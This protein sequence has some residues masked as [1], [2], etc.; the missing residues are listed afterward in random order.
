MTKVTIIIHEGHGG[1]GRGR[2][3]GRPHGR[4]RAGCG[5][6]EEQFTG[7]G[8]HDQRADDQP[9]SE[10]KSGHHGHRPTD[11]HPGGERAFGERGRR[12][13]WGGHGR[14]DGERD[15]GGPRHGGP[16]HHRPDHELTEAELAQRQLARQVR[17]EVRRVLR[18]AEAAGLN[19]ERA[20]RVVR[21]ETRRSYL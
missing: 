17:R 7:R 4:R 14:P 11:A 10:R 6:V 9:G 18:E 21:R 2:H 1:P 5:S 15:L 16:R 12:G 8:R 13:Q 3:M 20:A 19:P